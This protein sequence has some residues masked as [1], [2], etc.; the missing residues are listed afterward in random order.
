MNKTLGLFIAI[1]DFCTPQI[2]NTHT[3]IYISYTHRI[4]IKKKN[5][6]KIK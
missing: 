5:K 2:K 1:I 6:K 4:K 3:H